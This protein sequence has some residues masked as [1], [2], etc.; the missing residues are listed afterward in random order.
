MYLRVNIIPKMTFQIM[1]FTRQSGSRLIVTLSTYLS[2]YILYFRRQFLY[3]FEC[4]QTGY[5]VL[6]LVI[7]F[8]QLKMQF[9]R[10]YDHHSADLIICFESS[11]SA[12]TIFF[13]FHQS[14]AKN[15]IVFRLGFT[16]QSS[17]M[18]IAFLTIMTFYKLFP[19]SEAQFF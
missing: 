19:L 16:F 1:Y 15:I 14:D 3:H 6:S 2:Q 10:K 11:T 8:H 17:L 18:L 5:S 13:S 4:I 9:F 12:P 7:T